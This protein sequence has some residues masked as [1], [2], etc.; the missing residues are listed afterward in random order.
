[1]ELFYLL[2]HVLRSLDRFWRRPLRYWVPELDEGKDPVEILRER[3]I[4]I[5]PWRHY[6]KCYAVALWV[7]FFAFIILLLCD[8]P[9]PRPVTIG[10]GMPLVWVL[11]G[12]VL[13]SLSRGGRC[14]IHLAGVDFCYGRTTVSCP[15]DLFC[16]AGEPIYY[17]GQECLDLPIQT[18]AIPSIQVQVGQHVVAE[19]TAAR[20]RH[21]RVLSNGAIRLN[22]VYR[23]KPDQ[24]GAL[25][26]D[27]G[28][29]LGHARASS[30]PE[31]APGLV[32]AENQKAGWL[33]VSLTRLHFPPQ[34]CECGNHT[35]RWQ[36]FRADR[37]VVLWGD[38][39]VTIRAPLCKACRR[40][41]LWRYWR[42]LT[43]TTLVVLLAV[44]FGCLILRAVLQA[45]G[46]PLDLPILTFIG[47]LVSVLLVWFFARK[48]AFA[49]SSPL[50]LSGY[51]P[52]EGTIQLR[53]RNRK[54]A[55]AFVAG[56][57]D[58]PAS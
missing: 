41:Q 14:R 48:R 10:V 30:S 5:G 43:L 12:Q 42:T 21:F 7:T 6:A 1:M 24:L 37:T 31:F 38:A 27:L 35:D 23:V 56:A 4:E 22:V 46:A 40:A 18:A 47:I 33:C 2:I 32:A 52:S 53:F 57:Q 45:L 13:V 51:R 26:L 16:I 28:R 11:L 49:A 8:I 36:R 15:W 3:D 44:V 58:F 9:R 19:R 50:F 39:S 55:D 29:R 34:C 25:L 20:A 54:Y 17:P